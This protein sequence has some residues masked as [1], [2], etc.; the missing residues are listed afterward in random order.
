MFSKIKNTETQP[1]AG[2]DFAETT[3]RAPEAVI[4]QPDTATFN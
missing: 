2:V 1:W 3:K 4:G